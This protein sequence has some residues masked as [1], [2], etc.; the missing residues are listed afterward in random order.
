MSVLFRRDHY[1]TA[2][3]TKVIDYPALCDVV[4]NGQR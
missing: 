1:L 2:E 4:H 3:E